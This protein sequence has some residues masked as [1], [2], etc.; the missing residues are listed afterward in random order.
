MA[1]VFLLWYSFPLFTG[2]KQQAGGETGYRDFIRKAGVYV[3][4]I[5]IDTINGHKYGGEFWRPP[6]LDSEWTRHHDTLTRDDDGTQQDPEPG[7]RTPGVCRCG[8]ENNNR[9]KKCWM[10]GRP[11]CFRV[12]GTPFPDVNN[13]ISVCGEMEV[14]ACFFLRWN[15]LVLRTSHK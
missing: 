9:L 6:R 10:R 5:N 2:G 15:A 14:I 12:R 4:N 7:L 8:R 1:Q 11:I 3:H 13:Q